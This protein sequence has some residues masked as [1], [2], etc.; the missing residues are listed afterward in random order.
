MALSI[1]D[2]DLAY[3]STTGLYVF[4]DGTH[5][6]N[7]FQTA[8]GDNAVYVALRVQDKWFDIK[9]EVKDFI[10]AASISV[11]TFQDFKERVLRGEVSISMEDEN[12]EKRFYIT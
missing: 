10:G 8:A 6:V 7:V 11:N 4:K 5:H 2:K 12:G 3:E 1:Q 9:Y